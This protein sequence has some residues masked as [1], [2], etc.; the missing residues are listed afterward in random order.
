[1][2]ARGHLPL[3]AAFLAAC[4][5]APAPA[6]P[7]GGP[8]GSDP[9]FSA[10]NFWTRPVD[11]APLHPQ[12][13]AMIAQLVSQGGF[14]LGRFQVDFSMVVLEAPAGTPRAPFVEAPG[15]Y[16]PDCDH[17]ASV[18]LPAGGAVEGQPGYS[19]DV[20]A[21]DCHLLVVDRAAGRLV[22]V[23]QATVD[24][25]GSVHG[26]CAISWNL[27][28]SYPDGMRGD[29]CTSAD[30]AGFPIAPLLFSADEIA[31]GSIDHAIRFILPNARMRAGVFV[32]P[33]SHA[34]APS[35]PAGAIPYGARLRLRA[36][37]PVSTLPAGA[38]VVARALQRYGMI[39]ADGGSVAL[40]AR[41]DRFTTLT[42]SQVGFDSHSLQAITPSDFEVL[43]FGTPIALT[44]DCVRNGL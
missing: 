31:A 20:S 25:A 39:L 18:A 9:I 38:Q 36:S 33:A 35:G 24:G 5:S 27:S 22:E 3:L 42:W 26:L 28:T 32:H 29:Q 6:A 7:S 21:A 41:D 23:Y 44:Y 19:C 1:M 40:T 37:F 11:A 4:G 8:A 16:V 12:S 43:D 34:G 13:A 15:Y 30:A 14:G 17:L 2:A 10:P